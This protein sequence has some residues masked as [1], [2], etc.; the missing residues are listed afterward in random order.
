MWE[1][2]V[3][4]VIFSDVGV[5]DM[6]FDEFLLLVVSMVIVFDMMLV[7]VIHFVISVVV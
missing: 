5:I 3:L 1:W 4:Y 6:L 2:G 7:D